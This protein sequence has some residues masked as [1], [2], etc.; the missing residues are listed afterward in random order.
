MKETR[1]KVKGMICGGCEKRVK[2][3]LSTIDGIEKVEAD[4]KIG[5]VTVLAKEEIEKS[6]MEE[7]IEDLGFEVIKED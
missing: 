2:N 4:Y 3:T 5:I 7:K 6:V 1:I